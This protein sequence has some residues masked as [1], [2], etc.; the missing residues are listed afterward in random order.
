MASNPSQAT[1]FASPP[2]SPS[3]EQAMAIDVTTASQ[4]EIKAARAV[5]WNVP[6]AYFLDTPEYHARRRI[7]AAIEKPR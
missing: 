3:V 7:E 4:A 5:M 2:R 6:K 1:L